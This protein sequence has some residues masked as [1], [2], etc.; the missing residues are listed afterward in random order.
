MFDLF[1]ISLELRPF[2]RSNILTITVFSFLK[3]LLWAGFLGC[4]FSR[5]VLDSDATTMPEEGVLGTD[6]LF[7][8]VRGTASFYYF[9]HT[10]EGPS[11]L[12]S[13]RCFPPAILITPGTSN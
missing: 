1:R 5:G 11:G 10:L 8:Q 4:I 12:R 9:E 7:R 2:L 13:A 3:L 6:L